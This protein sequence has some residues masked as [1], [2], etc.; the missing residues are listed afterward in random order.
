MMAAATDLTVWLI[1]TTDEADMRLCTATEHLRCIF[2]SLPD[3]ECNR[4][5]R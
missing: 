5:V 4:V 1:I 2:I 3:I